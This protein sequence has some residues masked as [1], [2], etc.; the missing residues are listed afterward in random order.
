[1][2]DYVKDFE[3]ICPNCG[4]KVVEFQTKTTA[5]LLETV[6]PEEASPFY[7]DCAECGVWVD[8]DMIPPSDPVF[9]VR[10]EGVDQFITV[11]RTGKRI[12]DQGE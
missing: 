9:R 8:V 2:F 1:M 12:I 11:D 4:A 5:C 7:S 3:I 6:T 10:V